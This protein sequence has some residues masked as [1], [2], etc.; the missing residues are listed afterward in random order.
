MSNIGHVCFALMKFC[1]FPALCVSSMKFCKE[2][3]AWALL[4]SV[5][6]RRKSL[7]GVFE[8]AHAQLY[9]KGF[10]IFGGF[11]KSSKHQQLVPKEQ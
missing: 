8:K 5:E 3:G 6:A 7:T 4:Q 9:K 11:N 10:V 1:Y 2:T